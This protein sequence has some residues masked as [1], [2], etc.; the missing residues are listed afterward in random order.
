M[1]NV[2]VEKIKEFESGLVDYSHNNAKKTL[3]NIRKTGLL[4]EADEQ[5]LDK[6]ISDYKE[7]LDY[8]MQ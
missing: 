3:T 8:L 2:P 1:D 6:A 4:E 7:T 5:G